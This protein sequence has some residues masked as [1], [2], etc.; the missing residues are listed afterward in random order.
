MAHQDAAM[1]TLEV[2]DNASINQLMTNIVQRHPAGITAAA[3][4]AEMRRMGAPEE[5][6][7]E[8]LGV[9]PEEVLR[10]RPGTG[11]GAPN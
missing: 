10:F 1:P 8:L 11:Y 3:F 4:C 6:R 7:P 2:L 9:E 5:F